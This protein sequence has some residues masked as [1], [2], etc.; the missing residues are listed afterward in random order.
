MGRR[1][2]ASG[3]RFASSSMST[4]PWRE[5]ISSGLRTS[6]ETVMARYSSRATST[7]ALDQQRLDRRGRGWSW[8]GCPRRRPRTSAAEPHDADAAGLAAP[9]VLA[10]ALTHTC[11]P[12]RLRPRGR[13]SSGVARHERR[14]HRQ[15]GGGEEAFPSCSSRSMRRQSTRSGAE[16]WPASRCASSASRSPR[17][18]AC[19]LRS[20]KRG[21]TRLSTASRTASRAA[22][23]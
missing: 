6:R 12:S 3:S 7:A 8:P 22:R 16:G 13:A 2:S 14:Q 18:N 15:A 21:G 17:S 9:P 10:C 5:K 19:A 11:G 1:S 4:P 23:R 20:L